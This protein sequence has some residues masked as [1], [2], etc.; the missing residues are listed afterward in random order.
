ML[1]IKISPSNSWIVSCKEGSKYK[2]TETWWAN[3]INKEEGANFRF[4]K[5]Q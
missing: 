2:L 5:H 1:K 4:V 3:F